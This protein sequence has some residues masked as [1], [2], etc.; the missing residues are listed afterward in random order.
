MAAQFV[1]SCGCAFEY[2]WCPTGRRFSLPVIRTYLAWFAILLAAGWIGSCCQLAG[3][4]CC[5]SLFRWRLLQDVRCMAVMR[6]SSFGHVWS[7]AA[8]DS[9][10]CLDGCGQSVCPCQAGSV[11]GSLWDDQVKAFLPAGALSGQTLCPLVYISSFSR[12][13]LAALLLGSREDCSHYALFV[14]A[15]DSNRLGEALSPIAWAICSA[16]YRSSVSM[17][18]CLE[19]IGGSFLLQIASKWRVQDGDCPSINPVSVVVQAWS[20]GDDVQIVHYSCVALMGLSDQLV[21][22][23]S[24]WV[25]FSP[26]KHVAGY[27]VLLDCW[28]VMPY[29]FRSLLQGHFYAVVDA[30]MF[31]L[32]HV[33]RLCRCLPV[34]RLGNRVHSPEDYRT[35]GAGVFKAVV[36]GFLP[37]TTAPLLLL[38]LLPGSAGLAIGHLVFRSPSSCYLLV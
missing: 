28:I 5:Y 31:F 25:R 26:Q 4:A 37:T 20:S 8:K 18:L 9:Y 33:I 3:E 29:L 38:P 6:L 11:V 23:R 2:V 27:S 7:P 12:T 35:F 34:A 16:L 22:A 14:D 24:I 10:A 15:M 32:D 19:E 1:C 36:A 13:V 30:P 21:H 17:L